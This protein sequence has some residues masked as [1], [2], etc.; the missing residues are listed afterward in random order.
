MFRPPRHSVH[1]VSKSNEFERFSDQDNHACA[2]FFGGF[3]GETMRWPGHHDSS[4]CLRFSVSFVVSLQSI[5]I[6]MFQTA[7]DCKFTDLSPST[8]PVVASSAGGEEMVGCQTGA[9]VRT[10][11]NRLE[12]AFSARVRLSESLA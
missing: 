11:R 1:A 9:R 7:T 5:Y 10:I 6:S 2:T 12:Q 8:R 4:I 3:C